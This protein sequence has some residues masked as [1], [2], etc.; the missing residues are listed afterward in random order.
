MPRFGKFGKNKKG[1]WSS[2]LKNQRWKTWGVPNDLINLASQQSSWLN[3][4][5]QNLKRPPAR[6][7]Q[8]TIVKITEKMKFTDARSGVINWLNTKKAS[9]VGFEDFFKTFSIL[10]RTNPHFGSKMRK[11][12]AKK[13]AGYSIKNSELPDFN[14]DLEELNSENNGVVQEMSAFSLNDVLAKPFFGNPVP[15]DTLI[16]KEQWMID[17]SSLELT[18]QLYDFI[19]QQEANKDTNTKTEVDPTEGSGQNFD[20]DPI[21]GSNEEPQPEGSSLLQN[22]IMEDCMNDQNPDLCRYKKQFTKAQL[23][24]LPLK[25]FDQNAPP[26]NFGQLYRRQLSYKREPVSSIAAILDSYQH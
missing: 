2:P 17:A 19:K 3:K 6:E 4:I 25:G 14:L 23:E 5:K 15:N 13:R 12:Q 16:Q 8:K 9:K 18:E 22:Q 20:Q 26:P 24:Y 7:L 21:G 11:L 1:P 10:I